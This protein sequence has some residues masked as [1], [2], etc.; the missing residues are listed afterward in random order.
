M[1]ISFPILIGGRGPNA[2][3]GI[4]ALPLPEDYIYEG[5]LWSHRRFCWDRNRRF[6]W[7]FQRYRF[8]IRLTPHFLPVLIEEANDSVVPVNLTLRRRETNPLSSVF[9]NNH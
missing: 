7:N 5:F 6:L 3:E 9:V 4:I 2:P 8:I 1:G